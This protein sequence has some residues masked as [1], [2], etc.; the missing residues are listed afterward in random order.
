MWIVGKCAAQKLLAS[1][2]LRAE[3]P[4]TVTTMEAAVAATNISNFLIAASFLARFSFFES[5]TQR[6]PKPHCALFDSGQ[7]DG[8][9][10]RLLKCHPDQA[11]ATEIFQPAPATRWRYSF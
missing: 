7:G 3:A 11:T 6:D 8:R 2:P 1:L 5:P 9:S 10:R 4:F